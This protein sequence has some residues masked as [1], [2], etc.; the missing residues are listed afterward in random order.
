MFKLFFRPVLSQEHGKQLE[1]ALGEYKIDTPVF[2]KLHWNE[3]KC[4]PKETRPKPP[5]IKLV[6]HFL[7]LLMQ[8]LNHLTEN[9]KINSQIKVSLYSVLLN[10]KGAGNLSIHLRNKEKYYIVFI[11]HGSHSVMW[12]LV[13]IHTMYIAPA[14]TK[15]LDPRLKFVAV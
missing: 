15:H 12:L 7:I 10:Y 1:L 8:F 14:L 13:P 2:K 11:V 6:Y 9:T 3:L 4:I 5:P